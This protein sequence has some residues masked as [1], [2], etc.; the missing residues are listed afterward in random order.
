MPD[1]YTEMTVREFLLATLGDASHC[2][3]GCPAHQLPVWYSYGKM[4]ED[5]LQHEERK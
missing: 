4:V 1:Q 3:M 2:I 5:L